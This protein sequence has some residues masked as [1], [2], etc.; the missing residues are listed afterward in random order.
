MVSNIMDKIK[1]KKRGQLTL[2]IIISIVIVGSIII[3]FIAY[4]NFGDERYDP[5]TN[6]LRENLLSCFEQAYIESLLIVSYQG[7]YFEKVSGNPYIN[8]TD[9][10]MIPY[11]Y[12]DNKDYIPSLDTIG[13]EIQKSAKESLTFCLSQGLNEG[14]ELSYDEYFLDVKI[15]EEEVMFTLDLDLAIRTENTTSIIRFKKNP[16][17]IQSD[18]KNMHHIASK[19]A[20]S[21]TES[22]Q[23]WFDITELND[24]SKETGLEISVIKFDENYPTFIYTIQTLKPDYYPINFQF[25]SKLIWPNFSYPETSFA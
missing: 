23:D 8:L 5:K 14:I 11:Y 25:A 18:L 6:V 10:S 3:F 2:F 21:L 19:I 9:N 15:L 20:T 17:Y 16:I 7:G 13:I 4:D 22:E 1:A 12:Y 24:L